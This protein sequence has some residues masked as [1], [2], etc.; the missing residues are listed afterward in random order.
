MPCQNMFSTFQL[1]QHK[2]T[3]QIIY[4]CDYLDWKKKSLPRKKL[5]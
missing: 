2:F 5:L 1:L 3:E 4:Q